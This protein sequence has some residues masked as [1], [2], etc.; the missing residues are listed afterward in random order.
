MDRLQSMRV[1]CQVASTGSFTRAATELNMSAPV[2]SRLVIDLEQ[3]LRTRLFNRTTRSVKLTEA[4]HE[5]LLRCQH[6]LEQ[7]DEADALMSDQGGQASGTLRLLVG[8]TGGMHLLAPY[9]IEFR[10]QYP[11]VLLEVHLAERV[12]DLVA[13]GFD[14]AIQPRPYVGSSSAVVRKLMQARMVLVAAPSYVDAR[15][16]P[17]T[18]DDLS[19][20]DCVSLAHDELRD[21]WQLNSDMEEIRA[22]PH[23]VLVSNNL[24]LLLD[25]IRSGMGIGLVYRRLVNSELR[26]GTLLRVLPDFHGDEMDYFIVYPSRKY[27]PPKVRAMIGFLQALFDRHP[28]FT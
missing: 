16:L 23:N 10:R 3:H 14:L 5:Y 2:L 11:D 9:L 17:A 12:V 25:A 13:E 22:K 28:D 27:V 26:A 1:F 19:G 24:K 4:G 15:G 20:H 8:F 7:I 21:Y 6:I 18:P